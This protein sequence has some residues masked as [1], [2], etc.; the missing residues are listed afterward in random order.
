MTNSGHGTNQQARSPQLLWIRNYRQE[1]HQNRRSK[2]HSVCEGESK[3]IIHSFIHRETWRI[4]SVFFVFVLSVKTVIVREFHCIYHL[5]LQ[6]L[7]SAVNEYIGTLPSNEQE[8]MNALMRSY[9]YLKSF[10]M[11]KSVSNRN[12]L[13]SSILFYVLVDCRWN[14]HWNLPV[15]GHFGLVESR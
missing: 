5:V 9:Y 15:Q 6:T 8:A 1:W 4:K 14:V 7:E 12:L 10:R 11:T 13:N 3:I 2:T